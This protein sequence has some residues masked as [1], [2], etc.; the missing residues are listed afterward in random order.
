MNEQLIEKFGNSHILD[1][2]VD[3]GTMN[4][5]F[6]S[7]SNF[8][9]K[10]N[11]IFLE[12]NSDLRNL[13][14]LSRK[15]R[16]CKH[17]GNKILDRELLSTKDYL[18]MLAKPRKVSSN[19][20]NKYR[21]PR[22]L[23]APTHRMLTI[24]KPKPTYVLTNFERNIKHLQIFQIENFLETLH[25]SSYQS[26]EQVLK[27][28]KQILKDKLIEDQKNGRKIRR[29][30]NNIQKEECKIVKTMLANI[31]KRFFQNYCL[32]GPCL[33]PEG[34]LDQTSKIILLQIKEM[35]GKLLENISKILIRNK[36]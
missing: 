24:A 11:S 13:R 34:E 28:K 7:K 5:L 16:K 31:Y 21:K 15:Y 2:K 6:D 8:S 30:K 10:N 18:N 27:L 19:L 20:I 33:N 32:N 9:K 23:C 1:T 25:Q 35:M 12:N 14:P 29:I 36:H 22:K 17:Y 26:P 3:N 4:L